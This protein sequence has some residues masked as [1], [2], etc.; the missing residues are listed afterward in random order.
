MDWIVLD[1][2]NVVA[3]ITMVMWCWCE[4]NVEYGEK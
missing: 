1:K 3:V 4:N 2:D